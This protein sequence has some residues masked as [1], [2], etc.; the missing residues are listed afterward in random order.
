MPNFVDNFKLRAQ[1]IF[2]SPIRSALNFETFC[3]LHYL[4]SRRLPDNSPIHGFV[5]GGNKIVGV[6]VVKLWPRFSADPRREE[7]MERHYQSFLSIRR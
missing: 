6:S 1:I 2:K 3:F 4:R 7:L 5:G